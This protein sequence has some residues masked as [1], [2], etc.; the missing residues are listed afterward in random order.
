[1]INIKHI[2]KNLKLHTHDKVADKQVDNTKIQALKF[3]NTIPQFFLKCSYIYKFTFSFATHFA[4]VNLMTA[5]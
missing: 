3:N 4:S 5:L 2:D 1:M